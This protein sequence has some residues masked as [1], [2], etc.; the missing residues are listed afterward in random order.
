MFLGA[1]APAASAATNMHLRLLL[2]P[3]DVGLALMFIPDSIIGLPA[4]ITNCCNSV[5]Y[6][7]IFILCRETYPLHDASCGGSLHNSARLFCCTAHGRNSLY[8][9]L[10]IPFPKIAIPMGDMDPHLTRFLGLMW[11]RNQNGILIGLAIFAQSV[12]ILYN[13]TPSPSTQTASRWVQPFLQG[14]LVWQTDRQTDRQT[15]IPR[16]SVGNNRPRLHI[17]SIAMRS[18][19]GYNLEG[20]HMQ[21]MHSRIVGK[22]KRI[23]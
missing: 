12:P 7:S 9:T 10:G 19:K 15:D 3:E 13:G 21:Q 1:T 11:A 14:S 4:E 16:Y 18:K 8:F 5:L 6:D 22:W 20:T 2:L 17:H 23:M